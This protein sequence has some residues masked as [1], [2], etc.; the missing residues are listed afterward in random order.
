MPCSIM[1]GRATL[2]SRHAHCPTTQKSH[3]T[4]ENRVLPVCRPG[5]I[6]APHHGRI[7]RPTAKPAPTI[8]IAQFQ[9]DL[10][11]AAKTET[12]AWWN[13]FVLP[14]MTHAFQAGIGI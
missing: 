8:A 12:T 10:N 5:Y 4:S 9:Q 6:T 7:F 13:G 2:T 14:L 3:H 1:C 11:S